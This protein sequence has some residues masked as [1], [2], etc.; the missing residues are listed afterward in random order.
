MKNISLIA[1]FAFSCCPS[2]VFGQ[3]SPDL[4]RS[5]GKPLVVYS[6]SEHI[7]MTPEFALD[8]RVCSMRLYPKRIDEKTDFVSWT[9][10][11][12]PF[13]ELESFLNQLLPP[14][15]RGL[16]KESF[17]QTATGGPAAWTTYPYD[18]VVFTFTTPFGPLPYDGTVLRKGEFVFPADLSASKVAN[19]KTATAHDFDPRVS[20]NVQIVTITWN[21]R[22]CVSK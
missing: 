16:K 5:Y 8:G 2:S 11:K 12:L 9:N 13:E 21:D 4:E 17:G 19:S 7:S 10:L 1:L 14:E 20:S 15:A 3:T 22:R 6:V 18:L